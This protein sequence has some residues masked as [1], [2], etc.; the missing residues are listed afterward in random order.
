MRGAAEA[1]RRS[2]NEIRRVRTA[3]RRDFPFRT[4][5][6]ITHPIPALAASLTVTRFASSAD[7]HRW[8]KK[9]HASATELLVGFY[10]IGLGKGGLTYPEA[11]DAALCFGWI[12]GVRKRLDDES[13]TIRFTPRKAGSI[14]SLINV[15]HVERLTKAG[16]MQPAGLAAY[17]ARKAHKTGIYSFEKPPAKFPSEYEK[18]FRAKAKAWAFF[19]SQP[20]GYQR[21]ATHRVVNPK[22]EATRRRWLARLIAESAAGR[23]LP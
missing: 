4:L 1:A 6:G 16:K 18:E 19:N 9:N 3:L 21:L 11:I 22:Q 17:A 5:S 23:R 13:Y 12:D 2:Q 20:P 15:G 10:R 14:W 7:F 8:L